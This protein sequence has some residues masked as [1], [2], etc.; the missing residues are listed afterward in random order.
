MATSTALEIASLSKPIAAA[1]MLEY[2]KQR[3]IPPDSNVN[4]LLR[5]AGSSYQIQSGDGCPPEWAQEVTLEHLVNHHGLGMHYV[6]GVPLSKPMPPVLDLISGT[7]DKPAPY[8]YAILRASKRPGSAFGYSGG[9]FLLLQ[10]LLETREGKPIAKILE[11]FLAAAGAAVAAGLSFEQNLAHW[12]Y[13]VGYFNDG[14]QVQ[15][16]RLMFPPLAAGG[17][18]TPAAL[19]EWLRQLAVAYKRPEGCGKISHESAVKMLTPGPDLGCE[20]FMRSRMGLGMFVLEAG[21]P[22]SKWMLHQA[23]N[24]GF[25]GFFLVCFDGPDAVDGPRGLVILCNG[26][27]SGMFLNCAV[28]RLIL[29]SGTIFNPP[30]RGIDWEKVPP[31]DNFTIDGLKQ[32]EIVNL[33][34]K[35]L[36]LNAFALAP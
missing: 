5:E 18:G 30:L 14:S 12:Q 27:N 34:F 25:R 26:D 23:A 29:Q 24:D 22:G 7:E 2:C 20:A 36:V 10:H 1:F 15:D 4:T 35:E 32:E 21:T 31:I 19:A 33:G 9:G 17:L 16:G 11:P 28:C 3:G 13:A 6:N 8:G